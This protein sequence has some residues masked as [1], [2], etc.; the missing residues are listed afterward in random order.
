MNNRLI[1]SSLSLLI[2]LSCSSEEGQNYTIEEKNG[3]IY[4]I[5]HSSVWGDDPEIK[6]EFVQKIGIPEGINEGYMLYN[7]NDVVVDSRGNVYISEGGNYRVQKFS[8]NGQLI[9]SIGAKGSG[10]GEF[11]GWVKCIDLVNDTLYVAHTNNQITKFSPGGR[12]ISRF[13]GHNAITYLRHFSTGEFVQKCMTGYSY[14]GPYD[15]DQVSLVLVVTPDGERRKIGSPIFLDSPRLTEEINYVFP[16]IDTEDNIY[17]AFGSYNRLDKYTLDGKHIF[18]VVRPIGYE[19]PEEPEWVITNRKESL[20]PRYPVISNGI[21]VDGENRIWI[22]TP[23]KY[24]PSF[25]V[26]DG[27][28]NAIYDLHIISSEGLFLGSVPMPVEWQDFKIR[29]FGD[30]LFL[31]EEKK[32]MTVHE[33]RIIE[34]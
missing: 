10:P 4:I 5:N 15:R 13:R 1:L 26:G 33:Y 25:T 11:P 6:L 22:P 27:E 12:E 2:F 19:V 31:I 3:I 21:A 18:S 29:I 20:Q 23:V 14:K 9:E 28:R 24:T 32:L 17:M 34:K 16:E 7:P 30:R 8:E